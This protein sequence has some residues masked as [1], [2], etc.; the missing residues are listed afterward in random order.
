MA[1]TLHICNTL[2]KAKNLRAGNLVKFLI[3]IIIISS[4]L[5]IYQDQE[6]SSKQLCM[7]EPD[8]LK[9]GNLSFFLFL[10]HFQG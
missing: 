9:N 5:S 8:V 10:F 7:S 6:H 3:F 2:Q 4:K 1:R